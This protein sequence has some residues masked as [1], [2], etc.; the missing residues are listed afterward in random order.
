M[1]FIYNQIL[2]VLFFVLG[3]TNVAFSQ[4]SISGVVKGTNGDAIPFATVEVMSQQNGAFTDAEGKYAIQG[5]PAGK[6]NI[7]VSAVGF[8]T[9][10]AEV[11]VMT[12]KD[13]QNDF[14]IGSDALGLSQVVVTGVANER[15]KLESS[16]SISTLDAKVIQNSGVRSTPELFRTIPGIRSEASGGEGNTNMASRGAPISSGGS[17]YLQLQEDGLPVLMYGDM[18]FATADIFTR[19]D[20]SVGR[21]E[22]IR[23][24]SASTTSSNA[25][26]G[27]INLIS[28]TGA[29]KGGSLA[30]T[31][32]L[33][34]RNLR[35]DFN[36]G[37]PIGEGLSFHVGGFFRQ[38]DGVRTAGYTG[39]QGG[40]VKANITKKFDNGFVR[41]YFKHLDDRTIAYMPMPIKVDG[42][43]TKA[44]WSG[45]EGYD[46]LYGTMHSPYLLNNNILGQANQ[47]RQASVIDGMHPISNA[48]GAEFNFDLDG[49]KIEDRVRYTTNSGRFI[50]PFPADIAK[51]GDLAKGV[52]KI[53]NAVPILKGNLS[54]DTIA[55]NNATA[56]YN[57]G[58]AGAAVTNTDGSAYDQNKNILRIHMFDTELNNF[59]NM[60]NDVKLSKSFGVVSATVGY[61]TSLQNVNMSWLWNSYLTELNGNGAKMLDVRSGA[62]NL[63]NNGQYA[64]GVPAWGNCCQRNY[65]TQNTISAPYVNLGVAIDNLTI[66]GSFRYDM[67]RV[68]GSYAGSA[69]ST[70]DMN[71]DG[72]IQGSE[73]S[74]S[75]ID[76]A[77]AKPVNY[78]YAYASYSLGANY[79]MNDNMAI[80][81]RHSQGGSA[82]ADRI[83]FSDDINP[84]TGALTQQK[85]KD[86]TVLATAR[87]YDVLAQTELGLK[88]KFEQGGLF[89]TL[90]RA[91]T[92]EVGGYEATTQKYISN[93]YEAFGAEIETALNFG[94]FN[95][96]GGV[97]YTNARITKSADTAAIGNTPRRLPAFMFTLTPSYKIGKAEIGLS[98]YGNS[99]ALTQVTYEGKA[100]DDKG[101]AIKDPKNPTQDILV[102][103]KGKLM[104]PGYIVVNPY[105]NYNIT[106]HLTLGVSANN[107]LNSLG[108]TESEEG[109][110]GDSGTANFRAR[111][112]AG[113][114]VNAT[115][116]Y[117]F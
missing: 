90:F 29:K 54:T 1:K 102:Q 38:G 91:A 63:S 7:R 24:G 50:T 9:A 47:P 77:H 41:L 76:N 53:Q 20:Q 115:V 109:H 113:R 32:G 110:I 104:M 48:F 66:D 43:D 70:K 83:I 33:D 100:Y 31:V 5:V 86:G 27:I 19:A 88:T 56:V 64:Y 82:K 117:N 11:E 85:D 36:F 35:T 10:T 60:M 6:V 80:F 97:T 116:R 106:N 17:K 44:V 16:V 74:V 52:F 49:W 22:A 72:I 28:N 87:P 73:R 57:T 105:I 112:I 2:F 59:D 23:G 4:G 37:A 39:N 13:S 40:Q 79:K 71:G 108:L 42:S 67:G 55:Y 26:A 8:T 111:S 51:A 69:Q 89:V 81:A 25:P 65:N 94:A 12:G 99:D 78:T 93:S 107:V 61:F 95:L 98:M 58:L 15:S 3:A 114:S 62:E 30:T 101:N 21:I 14:T 45:I 18:A 68:N 96:R 75:S 103:R 46:P 34:Y 92:D 84:V